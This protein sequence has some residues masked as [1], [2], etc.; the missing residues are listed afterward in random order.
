MNSKN[1]HS[2]NS[3]FGFKESA[4]ALFFIWPLA[5][6]YLSF[7]NYKQ[8]WSKNI[9]WLF[10]IFFGYTFIIAGEGGAD[11]DR[12]ASL[13]IQY[14]QSEFSLKELWQSFYTESSN[15]IDIASPLITFLVSRFTN[16]SVILFAI[17]GFIFGYFYSRNIWYILDR[18]NAS[19]SG[20]VIL[21]TVTFALLNPIWNINGFRFNAAAQI[22]L[23]GTLP[24]LFEGNS[25]KLIWSV[26]SVFVHFSFLYPIVTLFI[27][28]FL[29][30]RLN[31]YLGFFIITTFIKELNLEAVQ[32][33]LT[34]LPDIF[35]SRVSIYTNNE[36]AEAVMTGEQSLNWYLP[37]SY[38]G[39]KWVNYLLTFFI[40][41][42]CRKIF[43]NKQG[44]MTLFCYSLLLYGFANIFSLIP[45]GGRF[46]IVASTFIYAFFILFLAT[47]TKIRGVSLVETLSSPLLILYCLIAIRAGMDYFGLTTIFGNPLV[48]AI[49]YD[50]VPLI[51][52]IKNLL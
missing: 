38:Q 36:Y 46:I 50:T 40:Y 45:S 28:I 29:G 5:T 3:A 26:A 44:L 31:I 48:A 30:N 22:F 23:F 2:E 25:K 39:M 16:N 8:V 27:F 47:F 17:F 19:L 24:Y 10:C 15:V 14:A 9:L 1:F 11:S 51:E 13:F 52:G 42:F 41:F 12:Y 32:S 43:Y 18:I 35:Q 20:F 21:L 49:Y 33:V 6:L 4:L 7:R 37:L 34:F